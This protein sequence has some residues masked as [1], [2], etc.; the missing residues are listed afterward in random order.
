MY[1]HF[2]KRFLDVVISLCGFIVLFPLFILLAILIKVDDGGPVFFTQKRMGWHDIPFSIYKFRSMRTE[3]PHDCATEKLDNPEAW[4]T[5]TGRWMR[6]TSLDELPQILNIIRGDMS[7]IGPR[8][9]VLTETELISLRKR[10]G[11]D[12]IRPG[13]TGW[14]QINGRDEVSVKKK[15]ILDGEYN[16]KMS[17][18]FDLKIFLAT[19]VSVFEEKGIHEGKRAS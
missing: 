9:V 8:P 12:E 4:I 14:A 19:F 17:F 11:V 10:Y 18:L 13:L 3:A 15:A 16:A 5:K 7:I 1:R 6:R 2:L